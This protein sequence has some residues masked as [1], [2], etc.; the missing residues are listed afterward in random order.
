MGRENYSNLHLPQPSQNLLL[1]DTRSSHSAQGTE[2]CAWLSL[3]LE[4]NLRRAAPAF[5]MIC[6][7]EVRQLEVDGESLCHSVRVNNVETVDYPLGAIHQLVFIDGLFVRSLA[8]R[9]RL[10]VFD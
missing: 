7:S 8:P 6:L 2:E 9:P 1:G 10:A 3:S 4:G 5:A